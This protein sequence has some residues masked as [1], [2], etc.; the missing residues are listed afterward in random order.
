MR[1][2]VVLVGL[3]GCVFGSRGNIDV[4]PGSDATAGTDG[5]S[6]SD[7]STYTDPTTWSCTIPNMQFLQDGVNDRPWI[8]AANGELD[9]LGTDQRGFSGSPGLSIARYAAAGVRLGADLGLEATPPNNFDLMPRS[10]FSGTDLGLAWSTRADVG[11]TGGFVELARI[12]QSGALVT[13]IVKLSPHGFASEVQILWTGTEFIVAWRM[14]GNVFVTEVDASGHEVGLE[15]QLDLGVG[16]GTNAFSM[17][18]SGSELGIAYHVQGEIRFVR[19]LANGTQLIQPLVVSSEGADAPEV[20]WVQD[21]YSLAFVGAESM[22]HYVELN[23]NGTPNG[24]ASKFG[25]ATLFELNNSIAEHS[26]SL[27]FNGGEYGIGFFEKRTDDVNREIY[28]TR[29]STAGQPVG[30][31]VRVSDNNADVTGAFRPQLVWTGTGYVMAWGG[32]AGHQWGNSMRSVC[33]P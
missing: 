12:D 3:G 30:I 31:D 25:H 2:L 11:T 24:V 26:L 22:I 33:V 29:V 27:A 21:H 15:H 14:G 9:V 1:L 6:G 23:A 20:I 18:W 4:T 32:V 13:P 17:A 28:F 8:T 10:A 7:A 5:G 16:N 19:V